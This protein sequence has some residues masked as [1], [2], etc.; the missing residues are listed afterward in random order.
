MTAGGAA[1]L[2]V[3]RGLKN[4]DCVRMPPD[5]SPHARDV[6][7]STALDNAAPPSPIVDWQNAQETSG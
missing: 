6:S 4:C 7:S 2:H 3:L 5:S 1:I